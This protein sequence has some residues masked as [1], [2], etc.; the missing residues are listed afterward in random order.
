MTLRY[1]THTATFDRYFVLDNCQLSG[2]GILAHAI[3][4]EHKTL[5]E[6]QQAC[7]SLNAN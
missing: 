5:D 2:D 4:S 7:D 6:A 3:L 1:I